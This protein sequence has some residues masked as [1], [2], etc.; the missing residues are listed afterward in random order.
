MNT[1]SKFVKF[2]LYDP[3]N[4]AHV[5]I[6]KDQIQSWDNQHFICC[7][8][9]ESSN[10]GLDDY[11]TKNGRYPIGVALRSNTPHISDAYIPREGE[12]RTQ[13]DLQ[14]LANANYAKLVAEYDDAVYGDWD[15]P[16]LPAGALKPIPK[17]NP[18]WLPTSIKPWV[19]DVAMR[20]GVSEDF[21]AIGALVTLAGAV[22]ARA[23]VFPRE[24]DKKWKEVITLSGAVIAPSGKKKTPT[25]KAFMAPLYELEGEWRRAHDALVKA[26]EVS[27]AAYKRQEKMIEAQNKEEAKAAKKEGREPNLKTPDPTPQ[28]PVPS[29]RLV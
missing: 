27:L 22:G 9:K 3:N 11:F 15:R 13:E 28:P 4:D 21:A 17:F 14:W 24:R 7:D 20:M 16:I 19:K 2:V 1:P 5:L 10:A 8:V 23:Q 26:Y 29:K 25:W 12:A 6:P 18:D